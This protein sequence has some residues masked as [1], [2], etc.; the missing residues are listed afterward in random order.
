[1]A[2]LHEEVG[3][4]SARQDLVRFVRSL[5]ENYSES[6]ENW[7]NR[8]IVSYLEAMAAWIE[9]MDGYFENSGQAIP[10]SASWKLVGEI[11]L[12]ASFYE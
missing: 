7:T 12:A 2:A 5:S 8:D 3:R 9:D 11:L 6:P 10:S 4:L 1:M